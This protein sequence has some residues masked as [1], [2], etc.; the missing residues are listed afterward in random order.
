MKLI[1]YFESLDLLVAVVGLLT[2]HEFVYGCSTEE[3]IEIL[4]NFVQNSWKSHYLNF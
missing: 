1:E 4:I 3:N 2:Y